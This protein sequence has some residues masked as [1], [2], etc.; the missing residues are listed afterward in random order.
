MVMEL[1]FR[2]VQAHVKADRLLQKQNLLTDPQ[3]EIYVNW[4]HIGFIIETV[5][6]SVNRSIE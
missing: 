3:L 6:T 5:L 1:T 2:Q 4:I